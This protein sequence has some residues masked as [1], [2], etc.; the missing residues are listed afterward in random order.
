MQRLF[1]ISVTFP[2]GNSMRLSVIA[3]PLL[4]ALAIASPALSAECILNP[5]SVAK[6]GAAAKG[7]I[8][9]IDVERGERVQKGQVLVRLEASYEENLQRLARMRAE[10]DTA[11]RLAEKK[12]EVAEAK[13]ARLTTLGEQKIT[14]IGEVEEAILE[15]EAARLQKEQ[16]ELD[17]SMA[18]EEMTGAAA[19]LERKTVRAP[20]GGVVTER[21]LSE[22]ELYNEQQPILVLARTD[23]LYAET[24]LPAAALADVKTGIE[25]WIELE[26][27][28]TAPAVVTVIDPV[29][30]AATGTFGIRLEVSNPNNKIFAGQSCQVKFGE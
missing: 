10:N 28:G 6:L 20:F 14:T 1:C 18:A 8:A 27:G 13:A 3:A 17:Q 24:Y 5:H 26:T 11:V 4:L 29:L 15:A 21:L 2:W 9:F 23:P 22:G 16:A 12:A 19:A 25:T 7:V 30:D